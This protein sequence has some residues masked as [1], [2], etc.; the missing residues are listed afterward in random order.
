MEDLLVGGETNGSTG[1]DGVGLGVWT[2]KGTGVASEIGGLDV[3]D[4]RVLCRESALVAPGTEISFGSCD[5]TYHVGVLTNILVL[6]TND[7]TVDD[8]GWES[9]YSSIKLA[10]WR[11]KGLIFHPVHLQW[12]RA[13]GSKAPIA[14]MVVENFIVKGCVDINR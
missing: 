7:L 2:S 3:L 9:V 5:V 12:A 4:W 10:S 13:P 6:S 14:T 11:L 1:L 8:Q